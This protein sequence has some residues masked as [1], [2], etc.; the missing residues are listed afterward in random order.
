VTKEETMRKSLFAPVPAVALVAGG[1]AITNLF[2]GEVQPVATAQA[3]ERT[4]QLEVDNMWCPSCP[5][6]VQSVL[7]E[8][9]GV[10]KA[11]VS[12]RE[13]TATVVFDDE[14]TSV[15]DLTAATAQFGY[16]SRPKEP[17]A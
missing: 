2:A 13:R 11:E 12:F 10:V 1:I 17:G 6:I 8:V 14:K 15:E 7:Q 16:P 5:C 4:V 3:K 9:P